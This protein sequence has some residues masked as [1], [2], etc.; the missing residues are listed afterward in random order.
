[1]TELDGIID[2]NGIKATPFSQLITKMDINYQRHPAESRFMTAVTSSNTQARTDNNIQTDENIKEQDLNA[3]ISPT[4]PTTPS[5]NANDDF[6]TYYD[7]IFG[8][9]KLMIDFN[10]TNPK[11]YN[12][13]TGDIVKFNI[14]YIDPFGYDWADKY[15]MIYDLVRGFNS[16][17]IKT[18]EVYSV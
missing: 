13:E 17:K 4:I 1:L 11:Y 10:I 3:Y 18:R 14:S 6:Y 9:I 16:I 12:I 8:S 15:F 2:K 5:A 7:N